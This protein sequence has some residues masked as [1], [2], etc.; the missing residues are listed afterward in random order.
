[1]MNLTSVPTNKPIFVVGSPRSGTSILTWCLGQHSDVFVQEESNWI[2]RF[3]LQIA[4][5]YGIGTARGERSQLSA[6]D[7]QIEDFFTFFGTSINALILNHRQK[8]ELKIH[9]RSKAILTQPSESKV[10]AAFRITRLQTD[11]KGRW[12]DGTPEYSF[13]I[14]ALRKLFP[15][16][17]FIHI[18]RDATSVVRSMM[19]FHRTGG[20]RLVANEQQAYERW[21][22]T[23]RACRQAELAYGSQ[24]VRRIPYSD[25]IAKPEAALRSLLTFLNEPYEPNCLEPLQTRINS[26]KVPTDFD[27]SDPQTDPKVVAE[28][29]NLEVELA[30]EP[31]PAAPS[32][33]IADEMEVEFRA[34]VQHASRLESDNVRA[35]QR[36]ADLEKE[37]DKLKPHS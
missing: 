35:L 6:L 21:I 15:D 37:L 36:I 5:A 34:R 2:G 17:R 24:I 12:V 1:M 7:V 33:D 4:V 19:N 16:A 14:C 22:R 27:P 13:Y 10:H 30:S 8:L 20:P 28:A 9:Q 31:A 11:L 23:V 25:L 29:K 26:S 32:P 3:A 18:V